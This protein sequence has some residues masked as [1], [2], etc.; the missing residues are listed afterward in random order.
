M[1]KKAK[2]HHIW[3]SWQSK[4]PE[5]CGMCKRLKA[6]YPE[7]KTFRFFAPAEM[8]RKY[9]PDAIPRNNSDMDLL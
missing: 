3:C 9:F 4:D 6:Q 8:V 1:K 7:P 5:T 2:R